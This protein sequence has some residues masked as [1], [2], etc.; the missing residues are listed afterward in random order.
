MLYPNFDDKFKRI[1]QSLNNVNK[2]YLERTIN[3]N[4]QVNK[5]IEYSPF[6]VTQILTNKDTTTDTDSMNQNLDL[7]LQRWDF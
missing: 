2:S 7:L 5:M 1:A 6:V 4:S 3:G